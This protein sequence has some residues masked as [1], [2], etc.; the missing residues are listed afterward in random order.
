MGTV[1]GVETISRQHL[2]GIIGRIVDG[3]RFREFKQLYGDNLVTGYAMVDGRCIGVLGNAGP[4]T[5]QDGLKGSHFLQLCQQRQLPLLFLQ[6][7][8]SEEG[9]RA[10]W[11]G[12]SRG[13]QHLSLRGRAAMLA[14]LACVTV[15]K[16]AVNVGGCHGD[17]NYTMCG[18]AFSPNFLFSWPGATVTH[19][20]NPPS[21]EPATNP[22]QPPKKEGSKK[23]SLSAF[24]FP[25]DSAFYHASQVL[26]DGVIVPSQ[27][28]QVGQG[29]TGT[30]VYRI[31]FDMN[32]CHGEPRWS[33]SQPWSTGKQ[34]ELYGSFSPLLL[35]GE[36]VRYQSYHIIPQHHRLD[37][38]VDGRVD[39]QETGRPSSLAYTSRQ[40][41]SGGLHRVAKTKSL[42]T[43]PNQPDQRCWCRS[44]DNSEC[45]CER[46][47]K[48]IFHSRH[49]FRREAS[50]PPAS[51]PQPT[52]G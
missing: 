32:D 14:A 29:D 44:L 52:P 43:P 9:H 4:L 35:P 33:L 23:R 6:N 11:L 46:R 37:A 26:N 48:L 40:G 49:F 25:Q 8:G 15:P 45:L 1:S 5:Y 18:P 41:R 30:S 38:V 17:D 12:D 34:E 21:A 31:A 27:T 2:Y 3:G 50:Q 42:S 13:D 24:A 19:S 20:L 10:A 47:E 7:S 51:Q 36:L 28:R 16:I 22:T 39:D